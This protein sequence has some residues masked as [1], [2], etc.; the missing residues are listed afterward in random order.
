M[1]LCIGM[2]AV[3]RPTV[4]RAAWPCYADLVLKI[5][6]TQEGVLLVVSEGLFVGWIRKQYWTG[7]RP[8]SLKSRSSC[9]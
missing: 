7:D 4:V 5:C 2:R 1:L 6:R 8:S 3:L 9:G